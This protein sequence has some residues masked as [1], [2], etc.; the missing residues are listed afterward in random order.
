[1]KYEPSQTLQEARTKRTTAY[2]IFRLEINVRTPIATCMFEKPNLLQQLIFKF[3]QEIALSYGFHNRRGQYCVLNFR[4]E[5][6]VYGR[7]T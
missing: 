5:R 6:I 3:N 2:E 4:I 7:G 1:M